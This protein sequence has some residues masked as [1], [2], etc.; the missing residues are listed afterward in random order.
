MP[1]SGIFSFSLSVFQSLLLCHTMPT[2][3]DSPKEAFENNVG[4][5]EADYS[6][7]SFSQ[8]IF[9]PLKKDYTI[10]VTMELSSASACNF[11]S[12]P[13]DKILDCSKLK[14]FADDKI[15]VFKIM[16]FD[17]DR[18]ENIVGKGENAGYQHFSF[19]HN[20]FKRLLIQGR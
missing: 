11:N 19:S 3:K 15:K 7:F 20:V 17:F 18:V 1:V 8:H 5:G 10:L 4:K 6:I 2:S 16:I 9:Y 12:L 13:Q 14:P